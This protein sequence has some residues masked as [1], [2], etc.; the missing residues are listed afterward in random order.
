MLRWILISDATVAVKYP[1]K[2]RRYYVRLKKRMG[3]GR[4]IVA[5][6]HKLVK[7]IFHMLKENRH[8]EERDDD[9]LY[10]KLRRMREKAGENREE[11]DRLRSLEK[12]GKEMFMKDA[13]YTD[14]G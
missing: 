13:H 8:Y 6:A 1:G 14:L 2:M 12:K 10:R 4:A 3:H 11:S 5:A 7:I 9:L